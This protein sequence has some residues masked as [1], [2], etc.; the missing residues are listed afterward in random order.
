MPSKVQLYAQL[1]DRTAEQITGSYQKWTAFLTTAARLY[2]Y[3]YNEQLMIFAQRPE[4]TACAEYDLWN[5]Q[6][7]RY[8]RRGSKGIALVDTS[9]DQPKL[10]YVFDVSDTSGGE[11]S[12]RPYLWEYRQEHREVVSAA[13]EQR[14]DVSGENGLADQMERVAAQLV[15]EYWHDN[16]R[17]IV[18]IVDGSFLEG[19]DDFNIGAAFRNAAVVSTTY[20]LL[21]RCG[22]QPGDYFEHEDFLNV[23]DFNTPQTVAALG[24]AI[25]Q[26]SELVLRQIEVTI[27]NY[28]REK[29]AERSESHERTD[30]HPQRGLSDSRSEP[31]RA[32]ASPA[33]QVWQDAEGLPEGA[34]S[35]AV[36]QPAAVR[37]AVP[38]SAGDRR[39]SEQPAGTDDAGADEVGGRD[40]IAES[41]RP[42]EVGRADEL[43]ES[44]GRGNDPHGTGVQ[45]NMLDAPAGAQMSFFPSE[46]EQI[47]FIAEAESVTPSAFSMFISQ[48]DIDHILRTGGNADAARMKI[49]AEFSKQKPLEDRAAFLKAL[50]YGGNGLITDNG[51]LSA[52]YGD[53]GIHIATGDTSRYLRSAQV[54]GWADAAERIEE[55]L[56]GGAFATNLEVT[57]APRYER[58][59]IAVDVWNLYHNSK[60]FRLEDS[61]LKYF[62]EK[63]EEHKGFVRGLE[64]DMQTLAAHPLPAEGFVGMEIRGDWL[65]DKENAGAALLD[66]CKEVKGKDP[67]QIG[68]YRGFTMSVAFDS[69]WKTYTLTL[70]GQMTHRV[71]LGS[72]ARGNLVRIE[73][74]LDKMPERL[75]SVQEQLENLYNQQAAAKAEVGKPFPQEQE[76]AAK[77]ARL[78]ELDMELNLDGKGQPQPEQAIAKLAR[79]SVLDRLKAPPVHGAPEKPH[80][81]E[82]EAR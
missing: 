67:V 66:T 55:L 35:G 47:Q 45:L 9:S 36:E 12:R 43:A 75:R 58:L 14:F 51:R 60:Q 50:Y 59:G 6:M 48:D 20:A 15:D 5:K 74:A 24:T 79:P 11:N 77:T 28:E 82:M 31:D 37:E 64:A 3:P 44:S 27:K 78:I 19:Y 46:A 65:T 76:L 68:S 41:Q 26:S 29:I 40:G 72:D 22:M 54:I 33:G 70:K 30:L 53:D 17:D 57:E 52:W 81:K 80:K 42:D 69:M 73:N 18:G 34:S 13:L 71:E 61:L 63:I 39:G 16:W 7:R 8:V 4:A 49:A 2:K 21:S 32:A 10:R 23:F 56:D 62:P 38:P 1:A 25:S